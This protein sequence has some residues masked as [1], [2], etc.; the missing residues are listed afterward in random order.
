[1][2]KYIFSVIIISTVVLGCK[3][4]RLIDDRSILIG[5]WTWDNSY[6][7]YGYCQNQ[8]WVEILSPTTEDFSFKIEFLKKGRM[9]L[10]RDNVVLDSYRIVIK[11]FELNNTNY[12]FSFYL[13]NDIEKAVTGGITNDTLW[14]KG[15]VNLPF[16]TEHGCENYLNYFVKE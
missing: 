7:S 9:K 8:T 1:M 11:K 14:I 2:I 10:Y 15:K 12:D 3:K 6:H 13:D 16:E 5:Q 4:D